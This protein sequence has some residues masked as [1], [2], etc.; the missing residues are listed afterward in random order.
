MGLA[1]VVGVATKIVVEKEDDYKYC[2]KEEIL[3]DL[4][5]ELNFNLYDVEEDERRV[6]FYIREDVLVKN[7]YN[8][9]LSETKSEKMRN[10]ERSKL[11]QILEKIKSN[12]STEKI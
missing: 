2:T 4:K 5:D 7:I 9:L 10:D 3:R 12:D 8:L 1:L 6:I 11:N